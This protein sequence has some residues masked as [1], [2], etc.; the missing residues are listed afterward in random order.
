MSF[1][2]LEKTYN[3]LNSNQTLKDYVTNFND[4]QGFAWT[5]DPE[6]NIIHDALN[7]DI[8]TPNSFAIILRTCQRI[9]KGNASLESFRDSV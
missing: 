4:P 1:N 5:I 9:F 2:L 8:S 3:F 7:D 6:V